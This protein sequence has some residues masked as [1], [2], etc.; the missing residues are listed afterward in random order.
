MNKKVLEQIRQCQES[1]DWWKEESQKLMREA[2]QL[3]TDHAFGAVTDEELAKKAKLIDRQA[4]YL[5][6]KGVYEQKIMYDILS[7][8]ANE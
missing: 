2:R 6:K 5:E 3:E 7:G 8:A 4:E 1:I